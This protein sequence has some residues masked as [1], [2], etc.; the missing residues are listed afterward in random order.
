MVGGEHSDDYDDYYDSLDEDGGDDIFDES[1]DDDGSY[2][3]ILDVP[4]RPIVRWAQLRIGDAIL[5]VSSDGR[6]KPYGA[7]V[8][9]GE[10]LASE[11]IPLLGTPFRIYTVEVQPHHFKSYYMHHLVYHAFYG[12][13]PIGCEVR[14]TPAYTRKARKLYSNRLGCLTVLPIQVSPLVVGEM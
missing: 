13:P 14:H 11:G 1:D 9:V 5:D 8:V 10:A 12:N 7:D 6:V 3:P 2:D 4:L